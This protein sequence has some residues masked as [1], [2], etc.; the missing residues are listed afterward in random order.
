MRANKLRKQASQTSFANKLR[1]QA[2]QTGFA[3]KLRKQASQTSFANKLRKQASHTSFANKLRIQASQTSFAYKLRKQASHT[4]FAYKLRIQANPTFVHVMTRLIPHRWFLEEQRLIFTRHAENELKKI[5]DAPNVT[6]DHARALLAGTLLH[7]EV[8]GDRKWPV[9]SLYKNKASRTKLFEMVEEAMKDPEGTQARAHRQKELERQL[10]LANRY[11]ISE[12]EGE[13][14]DDID[15]GKGGS[16]EDDSDDDDDSDAPMTVEEELQENVD[17]AAAWSSTAQ[18]VQE[19]REMFQLVDLDH[20]GSIDS[21]ELGKLLDLLGM[22]K[23]EEE[24]VELVRKIDTTE[25]DEVFFPDFVRAMKSDKPAIDYTEESIYSA[26]EFFGKDF[27]NTDCMYNRTS[28]YK[29][30]CLDKKQ[31]IYGLTSYVGKWS[32]DEAENYL[33]EAGLGGNAVVDFSTYVKV[34]FQLAKS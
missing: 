25:S 30:G 22:S 20:G 4:S 34:M 31:L 12:A 6:E 14:D 10:V 1:K 16:D 28:G 21:E 7:V 26:F 17:L 29:A 2:S 23:S 33:H 8:S 24:V 18:E 32:I 3:N 13:G 5:A 11:N 15:D 27:S 19:F 9:F